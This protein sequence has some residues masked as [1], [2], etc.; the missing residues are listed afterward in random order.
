VVSPTSSPV[1]PGTV[2]RG[3]RRQWVFARGET[4]EAG[5]MPRPVP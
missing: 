4:R 2:A 1:A 5:V 3:Q